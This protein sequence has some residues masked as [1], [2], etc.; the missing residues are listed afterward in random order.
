[1]FLG[2]FLRQNIPDPF[3]MIEAFASIIASRQIQKKK[4]MTLNF[5]IPTLVLYLA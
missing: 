4:N 1:L 3:E 2:Q 5:W